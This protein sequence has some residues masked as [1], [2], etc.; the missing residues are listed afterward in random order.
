MMSKSANT[1]KSIPGRKDYWHAYALQALPPGQFLATV[2]R[3]LASDAT[4][5]GPKRH[6]TKQSSL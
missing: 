1:V 2:S 6:G 5:V 4:L 3:I